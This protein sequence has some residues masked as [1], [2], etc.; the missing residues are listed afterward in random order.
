LLLARSPWIKV[1]N[2]VRFGTGSAPPGGVLLPTTRPGSFFKRD[3]QFESG[4]IFTR[5]SD[6]KDRPVAINVVISSI[7]PD[8]NRNTFLVHISN[9]DLTKIATLAFASG[10]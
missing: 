4:E 10:L 2:D 3:L 5:Y 1:Q 9:L 8:R 6:A 7:I